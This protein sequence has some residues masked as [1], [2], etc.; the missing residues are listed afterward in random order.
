MIKDTVAAFS[1]LLPEPVAGASGPLDGLSFAAKENYEFAGRVA[2]NGNPTWKASHPPAE[3]SAACV[4]T[5]LQAG[6][7]FVGFTHMDELAYSI[8]GANAHFGTPVNSAAP[9]RVPGGSSSGS[10]AAVAAGLADFALG[11]DTGGSV[12]IPAA[13]CGIFGLRTSH[14]R[15]SSNGLVP[16]APS[17]DVPG[18]FT[19]DLDTMI[20]VSAAFGIN[21]AQGKRPSRLWLPSSVWSGIDP[22]LFA[23]LKPMIDRLAALLGPADTSSLP[24]QTLEHW[25]ETFRVHQAYEIWKTVGPWVSSAAAHFG[26]GVTERLDMASKINGTEFAKSAADRASI[27]AAMDTLM[28]DS[29]ILVL[30]TAPGPAPELAASQEDLDAARKA[31]MCLTSI[32]GLNRY[33]ELTIPGAV[34]GKAPVGLSLVSARMQDNDLLALAGLM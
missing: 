7:S 16:L 23:A 11:S 33:P 30:P 26:P 3:K 12:R 10:A 19:R 31:I 9:S 29:T 2:S 25:F 13:F 28:D 20:R 24:E 32:S 5:C 1:E 8:I 4:D 27:C 6:A 34:V 21:A 15:I 14:G 17:F 18:W 22:D